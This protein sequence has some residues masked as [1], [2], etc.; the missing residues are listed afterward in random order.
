M[1]RPFK[2]KEHQKN[3]NFLFRYLLNNPSKMSYGFFYMFGQP[4]PRKVESLMK[5]QDFT[6][7]LPP[8]VERV[9]GIGAGNALI[10]SLVAEI[11][12]AKLITVDPVDSRDIKISVA[13]SSI[14]EMIEGER[15]PLGD[16]DVMTI[17]WPGS[18]GMYPTD[19]DIEAIDSNS[20]GFLFI[21][22]SPDGVSGSLKLIQMISEA[23][24]NDSSRYR[25]LKSLSEFGQNELTRRIYIIE[26]VVLIRRD[27]LEANPALGQR[28]RM[29]INDVILFVKFEY[30]ICN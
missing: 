1:S 17:I 24:T 14:S 5:F 29:A 23:K 9:C 26:T 16:S 11:V 28:R 27:L 13:Y 7:R 15:G 25:V 21:I 8:H 3:V 10:D 19:Y 6:D 2:D 20:A 30:S 22:Y 4:I 18:Q 12:N